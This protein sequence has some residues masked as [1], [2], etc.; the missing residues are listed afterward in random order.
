[1]FERTVY[2]F[3]LLFWSSTTL[4]KSIAF[5]IMVSLHWIGCTFSCCTCCDIVTLWH[6][7]IVTSAALRRNP[8]R[9]FASPVRARRHVNHN[10]IWPQLTT[11]TDE[12]WCKIIAFKSKETCSA[13]LTDWHKPSWPRY[14]NKNV[15]LQSLQGSTKNY[16]YLY[17]YF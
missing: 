3:K 2:M 4:F 5:N 16:L 8:R 10:W 17:L 6:C 14:N 11:T 15:C 7:D 12:F 13:I 9:A 1:M